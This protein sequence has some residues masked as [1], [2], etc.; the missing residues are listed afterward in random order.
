M[1]GVLSQ[2]VYSVHQSLS[3]FP[4]LE[5]KNTFILSLGMRQHRSDHPPKLGWGRGKCH[6]IPLKKTTVMSNENLI[7]EG[8][9]L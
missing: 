2:V 7:F 3:L 6:S 5:H 8:Y 4:M 1:V 9:S